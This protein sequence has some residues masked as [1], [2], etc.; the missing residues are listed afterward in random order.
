[1]IGPL[2]LL[3]PAI[4]A[5]TADGSRTTVGLAAIQ[6][7]LRWYRCPE[8]LADAAHRL[9]AQARSE[10]ADTVVYPEC[11][12]LPLVFADDP[13]ILDQ[14]PD[15][16]QAIALLL[17]RR[18]Q[19]VMTMVESYPVGPTR[20]LLFARSEATRRRYE[21]VFSD[22]AR[23]HGLY[24]IGGTAPLGRRGSGTAAVFS[25][26]CV[27][28]PTGEVVGS[29]TKV[30]LSAFEALGGL[31]L[32]PGKREDY[33]A[34]QTPLGPMGV[35]PGADAFDGD[36][37]DRLSR[38]GARIVAAPAACAQPWEGDREQALAEEMRAWCDQASAYVVQA[39]SVGALGG[40]AFE[41]RSAIYGPPDGTPDGSGILARARTHTEEEAVVAVVD[42]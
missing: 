32:V 1:M 28:A 18:R 22:V 23:A 5:G 27:F 16:H 10:G 13:D 14:A 4:A 9:A 17:E 42:L 19:T 7:R 29:Q 38:G 6:L 12:G 3:V 39:F 20:A 40:M 34:L 33:A 37:V 24:V 11:V 41:G 15:L 36:L 8:E 25:T 26:S 35:A 2:E 21:E 31:D 30:N